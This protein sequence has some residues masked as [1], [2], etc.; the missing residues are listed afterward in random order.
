MIWQSRETWRKVML[1]QKTESS[2]LNFST[3]GSIWIVLIPLFD[4]ILFLNPET[5]LSDTATNWIRPV[6]LF[7]M[8][9][10]G[11]IINM[12]GTLQYSQLASYKMMCIPTSHLMLNLVQVRAATGISSWS[13]FANFFFLDWAMFLWRTANFY[14]RTAPGVMFAEKKL[15]RQDL[16]PETRAHRTFRHLSKFLFYSMDRSKPTPFPGVL[17][18]DFR[19]YEYM[20]ESASLSAN[21]AALLLAY[22]YYYVA[23][24][25]PGQPPYDFWFPWGT[26]S[27]YFLALAAANDVVQDMATHM[28]A[29]A[30]S[31][32]WKACSFNRIFPGWIDAWAPADRLGTRHLL[33]CILVTC[34]VP[35]FTGKHQPCHARL[36]FCSSASAVLIFCAP[37]V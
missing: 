12:R 4:C 26:V 1:L 7:A 31:S 18:A 23:G 35:A 17:K 29:M 33:L 15:N 6:S 2:A 11:Y 24:I 22:A 27:F 30:A 8:R 32:R 37:C 13:A 5:N 25:G 28:I 9:R 3:L 34:W 10:V 16:P 14:S 19:A 21:Y 20:M 36:P